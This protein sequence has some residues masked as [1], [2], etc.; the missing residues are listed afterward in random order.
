M[1]AKLL[2]LLCFEFP[3]LL[4]FFFLAPNLT[5]CLWK[6]ILSSLSPSPQGSCNS[7]FFRSP[8]KRE[9]LHLDALSLSVIFI[10][11]FSQFFFIPSSFPLFFRLAG[12][13]LSVV[14]M[15]FHSSYLFLFASLYVSIGDFGEFGRKK[16]W[17]KRISRNVST[18]SK[19]LW[20][21]FWRTVCLK[22]FLGC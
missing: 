10:S 14:W 6:A 7:L 1:I 2:K 8:P 18:K 21:G 19:R 12:T 4:I 22:A 17:N 5:F 3:F 16:T 20:V 11:L 9:G 15:C 13:L